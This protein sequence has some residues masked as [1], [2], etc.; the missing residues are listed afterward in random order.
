MQVELKDDVSK[1]LFAIR[2][3]ETKVSGHPNMKDPTEETMI[4]VA[5][6]GRLMTEKEDLERQIQHN[7]AIIKVK[8][9][10]IEEGDQVEKSR[11][12]LAF[13]EKLRRE[14]LV[15]RLYEVTKILNEHYDPVARR[16]RKELMLT[17]SVHRPE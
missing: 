7:D 6:A 4:A 16:L 12:R 10:M 15:P 3:Y 9:V 2:D 13:L 5:L 11:S 8:K 17:R 1:L 14:E